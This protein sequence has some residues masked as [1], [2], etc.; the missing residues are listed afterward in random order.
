MA[1]MQPE[2]LSQRIQARYI[3]LSR[4]IDFL[5]KTFGPED[6]SVTILDDAYQ[7]VV[8]R[9]IS[10]QEIRLLRHGSNSA[11]YYFSW[12]QEDKDAISNKVDEGQ[13]TATDRKTNIEKKGNRHSLIDND[14]SSSA[15][16]EWPDSSKQDHVHHSNGVYDVTTTLGITQI[17]MRDGDINLNDAFEI[18]TTDHSIVYRLDVTYH[19]HAALMASLS[20]RR[21]QKGRKAQQRQ[22]VVVKRL[23]NSERA[24]SQFLAEARV[25]EEVRKLAKPEGA[26]LRPIFTPTAAFYSKYPFFILPLA[27]CDLK[28]LLQDAANTKI[29][30]SLLTQLPLLAEALGTLHNLGIAHRDLDARNVLV[31]ED[32]SGAITLK[33]ADFGH[34]IWLNTESRGFGESI[35]LG[36]FRSNGTYSAPECAKPPTVTYGP[37]DITAIDIWALGCMFLEILAF[38]RGGS[39]GVRQFQAL[40]HGPLSAGG[41]TVE[42]D[43][44]HDGDSLKPLIGVWLGE[45]FGASVFKQ[46]TSE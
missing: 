10:A 43:L 25:F 17:S 7:L 45:V 38:A 5:N 13:T 42:S 16:S 28:H 4:L 29:T 19:E 8:P 31:F 46:N 6:W 21:Q 3:E 23:L 33:L 32:D 37:R 9:L 1:K 30:T 20:M 26:L 11:R 34:S 14:S 18:A 27:M 41:I 35:G 36:Y 12:E 15:Q 39:A 24:I 22:T 2:A 44:F 40:R